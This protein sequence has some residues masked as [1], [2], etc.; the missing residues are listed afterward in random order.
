MASPRPHRSPQPIDRVLSP[1]QTFMAAEASAG[2]LLLAMAAV[3]MIWANLPGDSVHA[4]LV[5]QS[6]PC[7]PYPAL[8]MSPN[9]LAGP[10]FAGQK[11]CQR[12]DCQPTKPGSTRAVS[13]C[14]A[15][16]KGS[17]SSGASRGIIRSIAPGSTFGRTGASCKAS[18]Y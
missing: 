11:A 3:A 10:P 18:Q 5:A 17:G 9:K 8:S 14:S 16:A 2:I 15:S 12:G 1:I 6:M 4:G 13:C 7:W